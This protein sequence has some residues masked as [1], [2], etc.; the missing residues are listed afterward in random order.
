MLSSGA[1]RQEQDAVCSCRLACSMFTLLPWPQ[2]QATGCNASLFQITAL[3][4][5][6]PPVRTITSCT[7]MQGQAGTQNGPHLTAEGCHVARKL[8]PTGHA[9]E[10]LHLIHD[11]IPA[12][13]ATSRPQ[14]LMVTP[15]LTICTARLAQASER[16]AR[17]HGQRKSLL[18]PNHSIYLPHAP[19]YHST[20]KSSSTSSHSHCLLG[21]LENHR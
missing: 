19:K 2:D 17:R 14:K 9:D 6:N 15:H 13:F 5:L 11:T 21:Y 18:S 1:L 20:L 8:V 12:E 3:Q 16:L 7:S 10:A 4:I